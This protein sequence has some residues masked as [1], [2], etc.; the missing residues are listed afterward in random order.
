MSAFQQ[1]DIDQNFVLGSAELNCGMNMLM[2]EI[3]PK[4]ILQR[5]GLSTPQVVAKVIKSLVAL[6]VIFAFLGLAF[7]SFM[8]HESKESGDWAT[9][10]VFCGG[11]GELGLI[12]IHNSSM[13]D[14]G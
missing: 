3:I 4:E 12:G 8:P 9:F 11:S 6:G 7:A 2:R 1:I 13:L 14:S 5:A 10:G